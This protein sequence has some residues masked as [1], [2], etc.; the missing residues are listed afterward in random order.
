M[1]L[2]GLHLPDPAATDALGAA[3]AGVLKSGAT[4]LLEGD[5]GAGKTHVARAIIR[6]LLGEAV[7]VASPTFSLVTTYETPLGELW[8]ADLYRIED[9]AEL[10]EIGLEDAIGTATCL[11]EWPERLGWT[12]P[13][14]LTVRLTQDGPGRRADIIGEPKRWG[15]L[16]ALGTGDVDA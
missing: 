4:V 6:T 11:V 10:E 5:L 12:P 16:Q 3:I 15:A 2:A 9:R 13:D 14:A 8:H 7:E 1:H